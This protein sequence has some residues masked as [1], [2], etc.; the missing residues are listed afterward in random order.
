MGISEIRTV[1]KLP[2]PHL[3]S[4]DCGQMKASSGM[5]VPGHEGEA[6]QV[7]Q[8]Y[9]PSMPPTILHLKNG[10]MLWVVWKE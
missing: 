5:V 7:I 3:L 6:R 9:L 4:S 1:G 2:Q 8:T 10:A